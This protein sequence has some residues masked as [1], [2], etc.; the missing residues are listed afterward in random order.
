MASYT[1]VQT[2]KTTSDI[3]DKIYNYKSLKLEDRYYPNQFLVFKSD[4]QSA[5]TRVDK[6]GKSA[7][8]ISDKLKAGKIKPRNK[9]Q[10]SQI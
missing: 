2:I 6:S 9:E 4:S 10:F 8:L 7:F 1:G 3:I 5:L